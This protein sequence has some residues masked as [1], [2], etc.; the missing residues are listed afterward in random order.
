MLCQAIFLLHLT[1]A[2]LP[3]ARPVRRSLGEGGRRASYKRPIPPP[4]KLRVSPNRSGRK[5]GT[6]ETGSANTPQRQG[7][8]YNFNLPRSPLAN[9][10][11]PTILARAPRPAAGLTSTPLT[12]S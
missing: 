11:T 2:P 10:P 8:Y 3:R 6:G 1:N 5:S 4:A 7:L 9:K 12:V